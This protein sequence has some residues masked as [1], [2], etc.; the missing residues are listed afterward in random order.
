MERLDAV[1]S[2]VCTR[3]GDC[4]RKGMHSATLR[5]SNFIVNLW[6]IAT[7]TDKHMDGFGDLP[8]GIKEQP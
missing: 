2:I 1:V 6:I 3:K 7:N 8:A 4:L 5:C